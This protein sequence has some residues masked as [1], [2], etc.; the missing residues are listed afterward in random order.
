MALS[1]FLAFEQQCHDDHKTIGGL[2]FA[3]GEEIK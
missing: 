1:I 2:F 3:C